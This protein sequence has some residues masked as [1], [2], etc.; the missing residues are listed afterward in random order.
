MCNSDNDTQPVFIHAGAFVVG[1][2][3]ILVRGASGAG[4]SS[5]AD[6]VIFSAREK[7][8]FA[9]L[10]GDDRISLEGRS[11]RIILRPH[12]AVEGFIERCGLGIMPINSISAARLSGVVDLTINQLERLPNPDQQSAHLLGLAFPRLVLTK[13]E[14]RERNLLLF[15]AWLTNLGQD[16]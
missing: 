1:E 16:V 13:T 7:G 15:W 6:A 10:V 14:G 8:V 3:G 12:P 11:G 4:K 2:R 9:A 5:F